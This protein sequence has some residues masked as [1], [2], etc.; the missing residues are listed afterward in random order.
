M[1]VPICTHLFVDKNS[2]PSIYLPCP[3]NK[4][5]DALQ[6]QTGARKSGQNRFK[7]GQ[8]CQVGPLA[9]PGLRHLQ[10]AQVIRKAFLDSCC[11]ANALHSGRLTLS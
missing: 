9:A 2:H 3:V 11:Q 5:P 6:S 7:R 10:Q 8:F 4:I 1:C